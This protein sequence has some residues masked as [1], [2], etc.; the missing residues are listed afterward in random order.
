MRIERVVANTFNEA[1]ER[2]RRLYG[3]DVLLISSSRVGNSH[4]LLV[5]TDTSDVDDAATAVGPAAGEAFAA[6]LQEELQADRVHRRTGPT[7]ATVSAPSAAANAIDDGAA[8]VGVIRR[9]LQALELRLAAGNGSV[10][11]LREKMALLEQGV[12][13]GYAARLLDAGLDSATMAARLLDDLSRGSA[14]TML[15]ERPAVFVGPAAGGKTTAAMQATRLIA[16]AKGVPAVVS[17]SRDSRPGAREKFFAMADAAGIESSWGGVATGALVVDAG[18]YNRDDL[19]EARP[20]LATYDVYLCIP[21]YL[22]RGSAARWFDCAVPIAGVILTH[23][24]ET[25]V[26]LGLLGGMAERGLPL[27]GLSASADPSVPLTR[28]AVASIGESVRSAFE[29]A[30]AQAT[31]SVE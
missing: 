3:P 30:L 19:R 7:G 22:N 8:L 23:W 10:R 9:E 28:A 14:D 27:A 18:G 17:A 16:A 2:S 21:A 15:G 11:G 24:S 12:S 5:C 26:P 6:S 4:E 31:S 20:E 13:A 25:E 29:L 1:S